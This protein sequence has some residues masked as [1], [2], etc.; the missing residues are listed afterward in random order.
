VWKEISD[1][2]FMIFE[3]P[4]YFSKI[5]RWLEKKN[6]TMLHWSWWLGVE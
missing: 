4:L 2:K 3:K 1:P 5:S 6:V